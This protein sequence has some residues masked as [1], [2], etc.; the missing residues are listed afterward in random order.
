MESERARVSTLRELTMFKE[1]HH[2]TAEIANSDVRGE[3]EVSQQAVRTDR[4]SLHV[5]THCL[6]F[7]RCSLPSHHS[8][9]IPQLS[10][11]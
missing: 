6:L 10:T 2:A 9:H 5:S 8:L 7:P 1:L 4:H 11:H 3:L